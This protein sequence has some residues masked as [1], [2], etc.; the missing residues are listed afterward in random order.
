MEPLEPNQVPSIG[1]SSSGAPALCH[2]ACGA[3]SQRGLPVI[4]GRGS[5]SALNRHRPC[6]LSLLPFPLL[7]PP[8]CSLLP[9]PPLLGAQ[10]ALSSET[11]TPCPTTR[12]LQMI[13]SESGADHPAASCPGLPWVEPT[14]SEK[15]LFNLPLRFL[16]RWWFRVTNPLPLLGE[17]GGATELCSGPSLWEAG[18]PPAVGRR[19]LSFSVCITEMRL[20]LLAC[21]ACTLYFLHKPCLLA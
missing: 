21:K 18:P 19:Q 16:L 13:T 7:L 17:G 14:A 10:P 6:L 8:C 1:S 4:S 15:Y 2:P 20:E 11:L 9:S 3:G 12:Q 5:T